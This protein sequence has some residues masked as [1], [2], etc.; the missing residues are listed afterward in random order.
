MGAVL[1]IIGILLVLAVAAAA[2]AFYLNRKTCPAPAEEVVDTSGRGKHL[3]NMRIL[4]VDHTY[5]TYNFIKDSVTRYPAAPYTLAMLMDN[6]DHLGKNLGDLLNDKSKGDKYAVLL[7]NHV[8]IA[9]EI[10]RKMAYC[11]GNADEAIAEW[12]SNADEIS[13]FLAAHLAGGDKKVYEK[14]RELMMKH[15]KADLDMMDSIVHKDYDDIHVRF[16]VSYATNM[17]LVDY[18]QSL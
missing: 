8:S 10:M 11:N 15:L 12:H 2:V 5:L 6:Q 18:L 1:I 14:I 3:S 9:G 7:K 13:K 4:W 16:K 17:K